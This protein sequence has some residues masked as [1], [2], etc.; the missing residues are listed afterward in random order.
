LVLLTWPTNAFV[1]NLQFIT[2]L[3]SSANW[4]TDSVVPVVIGE[5]NLVIKPITDSQMFYRLRLAQ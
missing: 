2:S 1:F 3:G 4:A 5:Q